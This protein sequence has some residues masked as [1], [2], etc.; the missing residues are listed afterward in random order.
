MVEQLLSPLHPGEVLYEEFMKPLQI[1]ANQLA[2]HMNVPTNRITAILH[3]HRG[4]TANTA[5]RLGRVFNTSAE[6]WMGLQEDY[7]LEMA[8]DLL[9]N[10]IE[11]E[12]KP[13]ASAQP[14]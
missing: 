9:G 1:S 5:L 3:G 4:I 13:L 6:L 11:L 2:I 7:D 12:V 14:W 8:R 10:K